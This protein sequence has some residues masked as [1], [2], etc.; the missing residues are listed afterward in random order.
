MICAWS[1]ELGAELR[2]SKHTELEWYWNTDQEYGLEFIYEPN[3]ELAFV[4]S[5]EQDFGTG[6][7]LELRF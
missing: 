2:L 4:V 5:H 7:G 3:K 6:L 1:L